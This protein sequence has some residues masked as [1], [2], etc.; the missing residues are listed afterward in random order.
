MFVECNAKHSKILFQDAL[1]Y[2]D[3]HLRGHSFENMDL[4]IS[5]TLRNLTFLYLDI[6]SKHLDDLISG[7]PVLE[8]LTFSSCKLRNIT[9]NSPTLKCLLIRVLYTIEVALKTKNFV[10][11][12]IECYAN[13]IISVEAPSLIEVNL[14]FFDYGMDKTSYLALI[15]LL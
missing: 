3:L 14:N 4:N 5:G 15:Y 8:R 2:D 9:I 11:L 12:D 1:L 6:T 13:S 7:I 10:C